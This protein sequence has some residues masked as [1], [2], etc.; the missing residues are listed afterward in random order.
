MALNDADASRWLSV[1]EA[2]NELGLSEPAI[3][4]HIATHTLQAQRDDEGMLRVLLEDG[5]ELSEPIRGRPTHDQD[6]TTLT[7]NRARALTDFATGL[8]EP[9]VS[10]LAQQEAVIREQAEELGR[11]RTRAELAKEQEGLAPDLARQV[12][13]LA[14]IRQEVE[15]L[16][17]QRRWWPFN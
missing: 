11:L 1:A 9:L 4:R 17:K 12:V 8:M 13:E 5:L 2:A 7:P 16:G 3:Y 6:E 15:R 14:T 10:R